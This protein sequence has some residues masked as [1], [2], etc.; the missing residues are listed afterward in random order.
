MKSKYPTLKEVYLQELTRDVSDKYV[1]KVK[2]KRNKT[3]YRQL[4]KLS[5]FITKIYSK[6]ISPTDASELIKNFV[7]LNPEI[8]PIKH[9]DTLGVKM[10]IHN[11]SKDAKEIGK[12][13]RYYEE[14]V[15][16][17]IKKYL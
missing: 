8:N 2:G 17:Y 1:K 13:K 3:L 11:Q 12:E 10:F 4:M 9:F 15:Q 16:A 14:V 7:S 5:K 6:D